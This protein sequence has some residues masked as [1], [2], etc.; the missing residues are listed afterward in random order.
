MISSGSG[1]LTAFSIRPA[2]TLVA[3][4]LI[5][6]LIPAGLSFLGIGAQPPQAT[7]GKII[8][9]HK[10]YLITGKAYLAVLPGVAIILMVLAFVLVGNGIRDALDSKTVDDLPPAV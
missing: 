1:S 5:A 7:W 2:S 6:P 9:E 3:G 4:N 10:G 8:A